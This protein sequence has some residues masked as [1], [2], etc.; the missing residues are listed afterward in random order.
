MK[1]LLSLTAA[2][3]LSLSS[4]TACGS[5]DSNSKAPETTSE[6]STS[7]SET[8]SDSSTSTSEMTIE[9]L[10]QCALTVNKAI[11]YQLVEFDGKVNINCSRSY[12]LDSSGTIYGT[13]PKGLLDKWDEFMEGVKEYYELDP[14]RPSYD[15][16][17]WI[18]EIKGS[19]CKKVII[20]SAKDSTVISYFP[21]EL[22]EEYNS[23]NKTFNEVAKIIKAEH[24]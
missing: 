17:C 18:A 6:S 8:T 19:T 2:V 5:K 10:N 7:T 13:S 16:L 1:K 9:E 4:F 14:N 11:E 15:N 23:N 20:S 12:A 3:V 24:N 22:K 21:P